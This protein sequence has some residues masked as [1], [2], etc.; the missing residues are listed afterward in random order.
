MADLIKTSDGIDGAG[1]RLRFERICREA[2]LGGLDADSIGTYKERRLHAALK[3]YFDADR[4]HHE[5]RVLGYVADIEAGGEIIEI[6][7]RD[8]Y[9][10]KGKLKAFLEN[11]Y[12]VTV[13]Y[14][15]AAKKWICWLNPEDGSVGKRRKSPRSG[16]VFDVIPELYA[17]REL[18]GHG[19]L[20]FCLMLL[21][22]EDFRLLCGYSRDRKKGSRRYERIPL[23]LCEKKFM[24]QAADYEIFFPAGLPDSFFAG[25]FAKAA[26]IR[27]AVAY[28]AIAV[29]TAMGLVHKGE[30]AG[31]AWRYHKALPKG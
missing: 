23:A 1:D 12:S 30:K 10:M 20:R 21:E 4:T 8:F 27:P 18:L 29:L 11:G 5:R 6:Q 28:K 22:V 17:I 31:R 16:T 13:V 19:S 26:K 25:E 15:I 24:A 9:R 2:L 3:R 14:P 7:T